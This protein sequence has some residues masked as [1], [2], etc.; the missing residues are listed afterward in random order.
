MSTT[1][2]SATPPPFTWT[3]RVYYEDTDAGGVVYYANYL[4][5]FERAR[6]EWLRRA[7]I[8]QRGLLDDFGLQ[9]VVA[10]IECHYRKPARLDDEVEIDLTVARAGRAFVVFEQTARRADAVLATAR[11]KVACIDARR[12]LPAAMPAPMLAALRTLPGHC[13]TP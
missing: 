7:G 4:K 12:F 10:Q 5:F 8:E 3:L 2:A 9:F 11:V 1:L 13:I 6:T